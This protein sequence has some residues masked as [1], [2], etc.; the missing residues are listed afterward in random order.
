MDWGGHHHAGAEVRGEEDEGEAAVGPQL[1]GIHLQTH[2]EGEGHA[3]H[4]CDRC[5]EPLRAGV[6]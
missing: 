1:P 5:N 2:E 4:L 3:R 6:W